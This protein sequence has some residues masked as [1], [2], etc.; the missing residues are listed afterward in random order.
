MAPHAPTSQPPDRADAEP[1][2]AQASCPAL[3][4]TPSSHL[5]CSSPRYHTRCVRHWRSAS[6]VRRTA[7]AGTRPIPL[8][9]HAVPLHAGG[10]R[11]CSTPGWANEPSSGPCR[12]WPGT[13]GRA[14]RISRAPA[15]RAMVCHRPGACLLRGHP[16]WPAP[17]DRPHRTNTDAPGPSSL[18]HPAPVPQ[19]RFLVRPCAGITRRAQR[20]TRS[21]STPDTNPHHRTP[22]SPCAPYHE[23]RRR[24]VRSALMTFMPVTCARRPRRMPVGSRS[25]LRI[26]RHHRREPR[27]LGN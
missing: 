15:A 22:A 14:P 2:P 9:R 23:R 6:E 26:S 21:R 7:P 8:Q 4:R 13:A 17:T 10:M 16:R 27:C 3:Q 18:H 25:T 20:G 19:R 11:T 24:G 5:H 12:R 1:R